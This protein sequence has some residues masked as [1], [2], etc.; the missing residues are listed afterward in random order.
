MVMWPLARVLAAWFPYSVVRRARLPKGPFVAVINHVS[1]LDPPIAGLA[2]RRPVRFLAL[3]ELWGVHLALDAVL[4]V[5]DSVP[6]S[7]SNRP[8]LGALRA[9]LRHLESGRPVGVFPEGRRVAAWG[10]V[11]LN[12]GGAWLAV[13]ASVPVVPVAIWGSQHAMPMDGTRIGRAPI[14][15]VVGAPIDPSPFMD[16][17]DPVATLNESIRSALDRELHRLEAAYPNQPAHE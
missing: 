16:R 11:P 14:R 8:V 10:E 5:F 1:S 6:V 15:V 3:D 4:T 17:S 9:A 7:R 13:R 2:L 12:A